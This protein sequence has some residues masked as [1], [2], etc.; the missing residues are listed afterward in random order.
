[1]KLSIPKP[2][3]E[4][5]PAI[6]PA[7]AATRPSNAFHAM[8]KYSSLRPWRTTAAR[9]KI[10]VR[11]MSRVYDMSE[12]RSGRGEAVC[13]PPDR[14]ACS[15]S[16]MASSERHPLE[17]E[18]VL[19]SRPPMCF[20]P[21]RCRDITGTLKYCKMC[22]KVDKSDFGWIKVEGQVTQSSSMGLFVARVQRGSHIILEQ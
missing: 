9:S 3:S 17:S 1:M 20:R 10:A 19:G 14:I 13:R 16:V 8:V 11:A 4:M 2:A 12:V 18:E 22:S 7:T 5:L 6:A 21:R 15:A